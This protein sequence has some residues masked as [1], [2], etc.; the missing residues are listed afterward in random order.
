MNIFY[1]DSDPFIAARNLC[2]KHVPK[3]ILESTQMLC[4]AHHETGCGEAWMYKSAYKN[5]PSTVW[6]R[7]GTEN[8]LYLLEHAFG[9]SFEYFKRFHKKHA[10]LKV[11]QQLKQHGLPRI[12][13]QGAT[14]P[15]QAMPD[16]YKVERRPILAYRRY[17]WGEKRRFAKWE[18]GTTA[19]SWWQGYEYE[20]RY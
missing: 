3:M 16:H 17:Y 8:Y 4:T 20:P 7:S 19:P 18:R 2:D 10:C 5:H 11:L 1:T 6:A 9:I 15:P 13:F 14:M 12:D